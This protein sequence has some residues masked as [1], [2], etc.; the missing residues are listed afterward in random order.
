M[1]HRFDA[2]L[3]FRRTSLH[4]LVLIH[5]RHRLASRSFRPPADNFGY[6]T[7]L[8]PRFAENPMRHSE[9][10]RS[11]AASIPVRSGCVLW[12]SGR[13]PPEGMRVEIN[14]GSVSLLIKEIESKLD[15]TPQREQL[16]RQPSSKK[17]TQK[18]HEFN[19]I[20]P[21]QPA[22]RVLFKQP[23]PPA[24]AVK[25]GKLAGA[26]VLPSREPGHAL[27]RDGAALASLRAPQPKAFQK[28]TA[29]AGVE[30][31]R[32]KLSAEKERLYAQP[33]PTEGSRRFSPTEIETYIDWKAQLQHALSV[34][35]G[36]DVC[37]V[38]N[39]L[40]AVD[41]THP[42]DI[43]G[44]LRRAAGNRRGDG[45]AVRELRMCAAEMAVKDPA[46]AEKATLRAVTEGG[47]KSPFIPWD[48]PL[49]KQKNSASAGGYAAR[50]ARYARQIELEKQQQKP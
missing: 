40:K 41:C 11:E 1:G 7:L 44:V 20:N 26:P 23:A 28:K 32:E 49:S 8:K 36:N 24:I 37:C 14:I 48:G 29:Q 10:C 39:M 38:E 30:S 12:I 13:Y 50:Q 5:L 25:N 43:Y 15:G 42:S 45:N 3:T 19:S 18:N 46:N 31:F 22:T 34:S 35:T 4:S 33:G 2:S 21:A 17:N 27:R 9:R 6:P 16:S 47:S